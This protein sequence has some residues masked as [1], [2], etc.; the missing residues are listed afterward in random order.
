MCCQPE[1]ELLLLY[2]SKDNSA[3]HQ[4]RNA[5]MPPINSAVWDY[6]PTDTPIQFDRRVLAYLSEMTIIIL[7]DH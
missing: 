6:L 7:I 3:Q 1:V 4:G 5:E 2:I